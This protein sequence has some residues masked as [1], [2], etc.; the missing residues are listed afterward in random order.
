MFT[1]I[2][3]PALMMWFLLYIYKHNQLCAAA[4]AHKL[5]PFT[6]ATRRTVTSPESPH[7][8]NNPV[9]STPCCRQFV[10]KQWWITSFWAITGSWKW[11][12]YWCEVVPWHVFY[13]LCKSWHFTELRFL[14]YSW[15]TMQCGQIMETHHWQHWRGL[16]LFLPLSLFIVNFSDVINADTNLSNKCFLARVRPL[17]FQLK[18]KWIRPVM[19]N[20]DTLTCSPQQ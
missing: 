2:S 8:E 4:L 18:L 7:S 15:T 12:K 19:P 20:P 13:S 16:F 3:I 9:Q 11:K 17:C 1:T 6:M 5:L 10:T 14:F